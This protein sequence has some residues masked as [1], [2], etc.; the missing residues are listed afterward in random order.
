MLK[1]NNFKYSE[2]LQYTQETPRVS[3]CDASETNGKSFTWTN[4]FKEAM[5]YAKYGWDSWIE[6]LKDDDFIG[7]NWSL[8][9]EFAIE[10]AVVDVNRYVNGQPDC[11]VNFIDEIEREK[12]QLTIYIPLGYSSGIGQKNAQIYL[13]KALKIVFEQMV[14]YDVRVYGYFLNAQAGEVIEFTNIK[15]KDFGQQVVLNNFAFAFHPSFFRR[16]WFKYIETKDYI[17]EGS[18]WRP[19]EDEIKKR[20]QELDLIRWD[21]T[22]LFPLITN[23]ASCKIDDIEKLN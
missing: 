17:S 9:T 10:G 23:S 11:M 4:D 12:P 3:K 5:D 20:L 13:K 15:L 16:L 22:W 14:K 8:T 1:V 6:M 19:R 21:K 18:Y 2:F 7:V